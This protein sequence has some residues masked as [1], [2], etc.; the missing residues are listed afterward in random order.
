MHT[1][2]VSVK[3]NKVEVKG[4]GVSDICFWEHFHTIQ[5]LNGKNQWL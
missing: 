2:F 1:L 3:G 5:G 4:G